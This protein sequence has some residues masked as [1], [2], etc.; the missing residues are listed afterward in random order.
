MFPLQ[1]EMI[2][3]KLILKQCNDSVDLHNTE[4]LLMNLCR[5]R[6]VEDFHYKPLRKTFNKI[7]LPF[8]LLIFEEYIFQKVSRNL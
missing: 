5:F 2:N 8:P 4:Y 7:L 1:T 6:H 3:L